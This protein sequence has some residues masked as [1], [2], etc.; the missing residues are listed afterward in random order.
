MVHLIILT[1]YLLK[2]ISTSGNTEGHKWGKEGK[3]DG[4]KVIETEK[5][6]LNICATFPK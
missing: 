1:L 4:G 5:D 2:S 3:R 6:M